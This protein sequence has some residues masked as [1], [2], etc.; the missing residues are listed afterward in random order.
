MGVDF[1]AYLAHEFQE[2]DLNRLV[3]DLNENIEQF[4]FINKFIDYFMEYNPEDKEKEWRFDSYNI[5]GTKGILG[6][7]GINLVFS[8]KVCRFSHYTRWRFFLIDKEIQ[9]RFREVSYELMQI[10][11]SP[12]VIYVP[13]SSA[14][15]SAIVDFLWEDE[16]KDV[17]FMQEWLLNNCGPSKQS[18]EEIYVEYEDYWES[19]GYFIDEFNDF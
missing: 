11:N 10:L 9:C 14:R 2:K 15:E 3:Q 17:F 6:P 5:G 19:K 13:D 1:T 16:N 8:E 4:Q 12:F 18:I 7:C